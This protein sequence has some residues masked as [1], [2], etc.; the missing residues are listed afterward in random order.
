MGKTKSAATK[1]AEALKAVRNLQIKQAA[2]KA[3]VQAGVGRLFPARGIA[4]SESTSEPEGFSSGSG[5]HGLDSSSGPKSPVARTPPAKY[6]PR[7][8]TPWQEPPETQP[9]PKAK[10]K[11]APVPK[12]A[13]ATQPAPKAANNARLSKEGPA[14]ARKAAIAA[15]LP[16]PAAQKAAA[17][18]AAAE[19]ALARRPLDEAGARLIA[20]TLAADDAE[21]E[22]DSAA[23]DVVRATAAL[24]AA[25]L[26][27][28]RPPRQTALAK[29]GAEAARL[30]EAAKSARAARTAKAEIMEFPAAVS[31]VKEEEGVDAE[32]PLPPPPPAAGQKRML[33]KLQYMAKKDPGIV[34]NYHSKTMAEKRDFYWTIFDKNKLDTYVVE[35]QRKEYTS[36]VDKKLR[37]WCTA[38]RV[39][40]LQGFVPGIP[41]YITIRDAL[42]AELKDCKAHPNQK[43]A[44]LGVQVYW[45]T[46]EH[47]EASDGTEKSSVV[48]GTGAID[49]EKAKQFCKHFD[50]RNDETGA[51]GSG[52]SSS[53]GSGPD[54]AVVQIEPWKVKAIALGRKFLSFQTKGGKLDTKATNFFFR[55]DKLKPTHTMSAAHH[56]ELTAR[57]KPWLLA[58]DDFAKAEAGTSSK[59]QA[60][61]IAQAAAL[62]AAFPPFL[63]AMKT[64]ERSL[65]GVYHWLDMVDN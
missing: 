53:G 60:L 4:Q 41:N 19:E 21:A 13:K 47:Q 56:T 16:T 46:W 50:S 59:T 63:A 57:T 54:P 62:E 48:K 23:E 51:S 38:D 26:A 18:K 28:A 52:S 17:A 14:A 6:S 2:E 42:V 36:E 45:N 58:R 64:Y 35:D 30:A 25:E 40:M 34:A 65:A 22:R 9:T 3:T 8:P 12:A 5:G 24:D 15:G 1:Q 10:A 61:A 29:L 43:L 55:L 33:S 32:V 39:A 27:A 49:E 31:A 11:A 37:G 44:A 20:S 7:S